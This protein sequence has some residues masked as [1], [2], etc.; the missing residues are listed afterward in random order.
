MKKNKKKTKIDTSTTNE[1]TLISE[2]NP[3]VCELLEE[4]KEGILMGFSHEN[5]CFISRLLY[6]VKPH[7]K[8]EEIQ[9]LEEMWRDSY[10]DACSE[11]TLS[12]YVGTLKSRFM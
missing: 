4:I 6:K 8:K 5:F 7:I 2:P 10:T 9:L 12:M 3:Q 11:E 1:T